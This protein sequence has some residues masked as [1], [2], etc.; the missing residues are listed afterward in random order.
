MITRYSLRR[1]AHLLF[2]KIIPLPHY[3]LFYFF[4]FF[5]DFAAYFKLLLEFQSTSSFTIRTLGEAAFYL[6]SPYS[7]AA[8]F[9]RAFGNHVLNCAITHASFFTAIWQRTVTSGTRE[10]RR[11]YRGSAP[12][13]FFRLLSTGGFPV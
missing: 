11:H 8:Y 1:V 13:S 6:F 7:F 4:I 3:Y 10:T 5:H 12:Y 9:R 2:M